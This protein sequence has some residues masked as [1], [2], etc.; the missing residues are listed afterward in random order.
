MLIAQLAAM[1]MVVIDTVLLGHYGTE[2]LAAVAVGS[3][4]Y[5][6]V[7]VALAGIVQAVAP[8][9][10]QR[11]G[12]GRDGEIAGCLQQA[13]WLAALLTVPAILFLRHPDALLGL[14][15]RDVFV[16]AGFRFC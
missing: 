16:V 5:V 13:F 14:G 3:G 9:V 7:L 4:I 2:D 12:A 10:A 11:K 15:E 8:I 6:A 1:G